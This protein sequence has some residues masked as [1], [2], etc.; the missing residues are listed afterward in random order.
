MLQKDWRT[1][2]CQH[3][4]QNQILNDGRT[5][6]RLEQH[7]FQG[8]LVSVCKLQLL[9]LFWRDRSTNCQKVRWE[10]RSSNVFEVVWSKTYQEVLQDI[11]D[12]DCTRSV[13]LFVLSLTLLVSQHIFLQSKLCRKAQRIIFRRQENLG[14][15]ASEMFSVLR[16]RSKKGFSWLALC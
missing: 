15:T 12:M 11:S 7:S 1:V 6:F 16:A 5:F 9:Q 13:S 10:Q 8:G 4:S 14:Y 2:G 3:S